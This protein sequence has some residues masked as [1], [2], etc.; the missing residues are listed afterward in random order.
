MKK[1]LCAVSL[2]ALLAGSMALIL[3]PVQAQP[4]KVPTIK[5]VMKKLNAGPNS[6]IANLGK[7]LAQEDTDWAEV[8]RGARE[9]ASFAGHLAQNEP[10]LGSRE[11]W[12]RLT[13][14]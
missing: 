10:P 5:E 13:K 1:W 14:K 6:L 2:G 9:F 7:E 8:Q 3:P 4:D 11:S 12:G